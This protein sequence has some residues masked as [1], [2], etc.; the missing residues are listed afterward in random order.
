VD[1]SEFYRDARRDL[2]GPL[3]GI[4]VLEATTTWAGPM[5]GCLLADFG[6]RVIKVEHPA[7]EVGRKLRPQL[8]DSAL[9]LPH[10]TVNRN[11]QSV[12]VNLSTPAGRGVFLEL[13]R[14]ADIVIENFRPGTMAGWGVGYVDVRAV[15]AA[16]VYV[17]VSGFGQFGPLSRRV[18]YDP[19]AQSYSGFASLNGE[20]DGGP[21][22][23]ATFLG[24]D[25][26]GM[27]A[28]LGALAALRHRDRTGEGQHVDVALVDA[29]L[30]QSNGNLTAGALG[31]EVPRLGNHF[32]V[33]A[34]TNMYRCLDGWVYAGVLMDAHWQRLAEMIGGARLAADPRYAA[35]ASR[36]A[37]RDDVDALLA[38]WCS[39][40]T[41]A[42][43]TT[44]FETLGLPATRVHTYAEAAAEP[45]VAERDMLQPTRLQDGS[46]AAIVGPAAKFSRTPVRVRTAT[47]AL[48]AS[49]VEILREFGYGDDS[50]AQL[51]RD[52][53]I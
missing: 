31:M 29:L 25:L 41:V 37:H 20:P 45:H 44:A 4:F 26:G 42:D 5:A 2:N 47:E 24:D 32:A 27:H 39:T 50:I 11:K 9:S 3:H 40:R 6:A 34:P 10:E 33:S 8:P 43:V 15:N 16:V 18:A 51:R 23:A 46:E 7:G 48:G 22:K 19:I 14:H 21:V 1:K 30:F 38:E 17:S 28:A 36:L 53:A 49:T 35:L 13:A 52:G 12:T